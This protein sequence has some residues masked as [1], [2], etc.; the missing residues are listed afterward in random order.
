MEIL[1]AVKSCFDDWLAARGGAGASEDAAI[2]A[3]V[4]L[5]IEQHGASRFQDADNPNATCINR[6]GFRR[7]A[8]DRTEYIVLPESFKKEV[9]KGYSARRAGE[10]LRSA[11]WLRLS[12]GKSTT[13]RDLPGMGRVR[14]YVLTFPDEPGGSDALS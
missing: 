6:V 14:T 12:D 9:I 7:K 3:A 11:G 13:K 1:P 5:F 2:L 10:V 8:G 4:R